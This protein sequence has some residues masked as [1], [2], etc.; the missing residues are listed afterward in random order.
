MKDFL[1]FFIAV[2]MN[3]SRY[4]SPYQIQRIPSVFNRYI[5]SEIDIFAHYRISKNFLYSIPDVKFAFNFQH[6]NF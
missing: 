2:S 3:G 5:D 6:P 4:K 1:S